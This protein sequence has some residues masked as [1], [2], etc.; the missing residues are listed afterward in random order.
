MKDFSKQMSYLFPDI[1]KEIKPLSKEHF[2]QILP[3]CSEELAGR[4][5]AG[6]ANQIRE[7]LFKENDG[8]IVERYFCSE[9]NYEF[10]K[11]EANWSYC[12]SCLE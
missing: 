6:G 7:E 8:R 4:I 2:E 3:D 9:C 5:R 10:Q 1:I 11:D 12:A